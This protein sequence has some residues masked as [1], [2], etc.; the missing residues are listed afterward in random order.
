MIGTRSTWDVN[1][2]VVVFM[3]S[4]RLDVV[5]A[6]AACTSAAAA[7]GST[8]VV[9][10]QRSSL[11]PGAPAHRVRNKLHQRRVFAH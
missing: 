1:V 9:L 11:Q 10:R 5:A 6:A 3:L 4:F 2:F 7:A 8:G